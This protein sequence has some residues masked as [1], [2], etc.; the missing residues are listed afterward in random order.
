M[1]N[2]KIADRTF[3]IEENFAV[4]IHKIILSTL[5]LDIFVFK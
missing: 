2:L 5:V 3:F 4:I 1:L